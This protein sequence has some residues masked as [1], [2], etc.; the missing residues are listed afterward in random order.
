M[1]DTGVEKLLEIARKETD[2]RIENLLE[3]ISVYDI[4]NIFTN[5]IREKVSIKDINFITMK[6]CEYLNEQ[7]DVKE[8]A[9]KLKADLEW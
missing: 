1:T 6:L 8:F 5:L 3:H 4:K 2:S 7:V 9:E